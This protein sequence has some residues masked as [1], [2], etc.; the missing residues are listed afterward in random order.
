MPKFLEPFENSN[1]TSDRRFR[2]IF[3]IRLHM[4]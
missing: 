1:A 3:Y 4:C 2:A